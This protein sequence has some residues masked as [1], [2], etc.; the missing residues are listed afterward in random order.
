MRITED[1][2]NRAIEITYDK[3]FTSNPNLAAMRSGGI[4]DGLF[5]KS[6]LTPMDEDLHSL[7]KAVLQD[8]AKRRE[9]MSDKN[10]VVPEEQA[11]PATNSPIYTQ[12]KC[13]WCRGTGCVSMI[14]T[15]HHDGV[16]G[17]KRCTHCEDGK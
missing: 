12:A 6:L 14:N 15:G 5:S 3:L 17:D 9:E 2:I 16:T 4:L 10:I 1:E 11:K 8:F 7:V 13:P